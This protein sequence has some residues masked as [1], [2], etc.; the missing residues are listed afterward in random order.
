MLALSVNA[1]EVAP[2]TPVV[3]WGAQ[4]EIIITNDLTEKYGDGNWCL[5][6]DAQQWIEYSYDGT[7]DGGT[8]QTSNRNN[9]WFDFNSEAE[10]CDD[11]IVTSEELN[12]GGYLSVINKAG[13]KDGLMVVGKNR[14]PTFYVTGTDKAKFYFSGASGTKGYPQIEVYEVGSATPVATYTGDYGLTK[15]TWD[16][17]TLLI[18][19]GLN[20]AKSYKIV[21][22]TMALVDD[23]Y[24]YEGGDVVLQVV[25][26]YG[27]QA[28]MRDDGL[29]I[30]GSEIGSYI[31]QHLAVYP[32]ITDF[33]L[34]A[35][36]K[37]TIKEGI[38]A[39]GKFTLTGVASNP[40][41]I[42]A[43]ALAEPFVQFATIAEDAEKDENGFVAATNVRFA[44]IKVNA[45]GQSLFSSGKQNYLI[46]E[47]T[48]DNS[49]V[50]LTG[51]PFVFDFRSGG[52][53]AK[54]AVSNSTVWAANTTSN[55][56]FTSQSGK[57]AT[58]AGLEEQ[59]LSI[60]NSTLSNIAAGRNFCTHRQNGQAWMTYEVKN[61]IIVNCGKDN[62]LASLNGGASSANPKYI[63]EGITVLKTIQDETET[64][65]LTSINDQQSTSDET[66]EIVSPI[67]GVPFTLANA[68]AGN[69][70]LI[71]SS[72]QAKYMT[73]D[74]RWLTPYTTDAIKIEVDQY[75]N[76]D[77]AAVLNE[78]LKISEQPSSITI[79]FYEAGEYPLTQP[80]NTTSPITILHGY[81]IDAGEA[82]IVVHNGMTLGGAIKIDGVN[83]KAGDDLTEPI[84][85]LQGNPYMM[86]DNGYYNLSKIQLQNL[87][88]TDLK[89][90]LIQG[91][92][93][94][95][96]PE[97]ETRNCEIYMADKISGSGN[98][99]AIYDFRMGGVPVTW[100][101]VNSTLD[102]NNNC[103]ISTA[104]GEKAGNVAGVTMQ[105][106]SITNSTI[107]RTAARA[108][109]HRQNSQSWLRYILK[110]SLI[111][112]PAKDN[113]VADMNGG[114]QNSRPVW[115]ISGNAFQRIEDGVATD[116][117]ASQDN[118]DSDEPVMNS[119]LGTMAFNSL[120]TP[121]FGG[122]FTLSESCKT[123]TGLGDPRWSIAY[124]GGEVNTLMEEALAL[125]ADDEAVAVGKLRDAIQWAKDNSDESK[126]QAA[127]DQFKADN[128]D[129]LKDETE[130]VGTDTNS[131]SVGSGN[132]SHKATY[133]HNGIIL[134]EH[135]GETRVGT[136]LSQEVSV[137]N[138]TYNIEVYA[139]SHNA[140]NGS[141]MPVS[142][143]NPAPALQTDANDVAYVFGTSGANTV[144]T[145]IT[146][147]RN[148][149]ML[150]FEPEAYAINDVEV[151][152]GKL[153]IGLALAKAG[154]TEWHTIQIKS[155]KWV[156]TA[157]TAYA[158]SQAEL[159]A[160]VAEAKTLA[161]DA[162]KT[163]GREEFIAVL[164]TA[165][166]A[167]GSN[168]YNIPEVEALIVNLK[169]AI[170]KYR[171]A[172]YFIDF[173][174]GEYY[175]IDTESGLMMAAGHDWGTR[176]IVNELGLDL[177]L[178]PNE[179]TRS[180]S[181]NSRV[182]N[183]GYQN[184]LGFNLYMDADEYGWFLDYQGSS[185]YITNGEGQYISID[186]N[187]NLVMSSTPREWNIVTKDGMMEQRL[188]ELKAA[189]QSD[190]RDATFLL[191][192]PN[193]N[194]NDQ[195]TAAWTVSE[196]CTN[197]TLGGPVYG[198][199]ENYCAESYHSTFTISQNITGAPAGLY[200]L[201]AQG[202][203]RQ[204]DGA[205]ENAPVFFIGSATGE[206]PVIS[207]SENSMADA[208]ASFAAGLYTID[209]IEFYYDGESSLT[210]GIE[211]TATHQWVAFDNFRL[212]YLGNDIDDGTVKLPK[213]LEIVSYG[214]IYKDDSGND[215]FAP[216]NV[217]VDGNDVYFQG[218]SYF[219]PEAWVKGTKDGN[220]VT[221]PA[222]QYVGMH[223]VFGS[224]FCFYNGDA[225]FTYDA[226]TDTYTAEGEFYG[227]MGDIYYDRYV[228]NPVIKRVV[229]MAAMPA[230]PEIAN[231]KNLGYY[232]WYL[233]FNV[234]LVD[235]NGTPLLTSKLAYK[236]YSDT[237]GVIE[238]L[239]FTP[240]THTHLTENMTEIPYGFTDDWD[241]YPTQL[242]LN[243]LYSEEWDKIGIQSIYY[244]GGEVNTTE[245][246]W[247]DLRLV[248]APEDLV[249]QTYGFSAYDTYYSRDVTGEVQ[250]G[251]YG[252]DEVYIQGLSKYLP[253]A[254]V[255]GM[256]VDGTL[257][258]PQTYLGIYSDDDEWT[259]D[260]DVF[261]TGATFSYNEEAGTF[262]SDGGYVSYESPEA[263]YYM[264]EFKYVLLTK[265]LDVAAIPANPEITNFN[266]L[267][268]DYPILQFEI[269]TV[270]INGNSL[271]L[272][273][274]AY[275]IYY[276]KNNDVTTLVLTKDLYPEL[277]ADK[278]ELPYGFKAGDIYPTVIY[279]NQPVE[280][281]D[282]WQMIGIQSIYYGGYE[283][284][285]SD[286]VWFI[287]DNVDGI[288]SVDNAKMDN[289]P[290]YNLAGQRLN[291]PQRG[292]NIINGKKL[293][294]K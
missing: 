178:T 218:M 244:G 228:L 83:L 95:Q 277:D 271:I 90:Q 17:S 272:S 287:N 181:I 260:C 120:E 61:S 239:T 243:G 127:I 267:D 170:D 26:F 274:L 234:P 102:A 47:L 28:P 220:T 217:A 250:V 84:I 129:Q 53:V 257:T 189:A 242:Y 198:N 115:Q 134:I 59:V 125:A 159:A 248:R 13:S 91:I 37:Y 185:F 41:T 160:L 174:V 150:D 154:Q 94:L 43:S 164:E 74:P 110:N 238:A 259:D 268:T 48:V 40:A 209:P 101:F 240:E 176:G 263:E 247:Y 168:W 2:R 212:T 162:S 19:D 202:F 111:I 173:A 294:I 133:D 34:D 199:V 188:E 97:I 165:E 147:R 290:V 7:T 35:G 270:D 52:V 219:F 177:I 100:N 119:V 236:I 163:N 25:K 215:G 180:V 15:S 123:P 112:D 187:N 233:N 142:D 280:Q 85:T 81:D 208:G 201:T 55:Q 5:T 139:T 153:T 192:N 75:E 9:V 152:D 11:M 73:G 80:I 273:K 105:T 158:A 279:L 32:G 78:G 98:T 156:T 231:M 265:L 205:E 54:L 289:V 195:R 42:D 230:N 193:F 211:G 20:K 155:L 86:Q 128:A 57:K 197:K 106:F 63:V 118:G 62:F 206:V 87:K 76:T 229:D 82:T 196:D 24:T 149:G 286:I 124:A 210:V 103:I 283:R 36:G 137:E 223:D 116:L 66:E 107:Y 6:A 264:D 44:N 284:N 99:P 184:Y 71:A 251:F 172:N 214:M 145:W 261:F 166:P 226:E 69:F 64:D 224:S 148:S 292:L 245:I 23:S 8:V 146:A 222:M 227:I 144:Q 256:L 171:K 167:V 235:I 31:N 203:Y 278:T 293:M 77:F 175:I 252:E 140:W 108:F 117:A 92:S 33:T 121:D 241:F 262:Y 237:K 51:N 65:V 16:H 113:F 138:G 50:E 1:Q 130:K 183:G 56:F 114:Q 254:W 276:F 275:Q 182:S 266:Y 190:P 21:A 68:L 291:K 221:F 122:T 204:E 4:A 88:V 151:T 96:I 191:Q 186:M 60:T 246:Q 232:G 18:A 132:N 194:R 255:K 93:G 161:A 109:Q 89:T 135:F 79:Q 3:S 200:Q 282:S 104:G 22:R 29:I 249:T 12:W 157:K 288:R 253:K 225:V 258:I 27:D 216:V 126:L 14:Y 58:E 285:V 131:W 141:Y 39:S 281:I 143:D 67:D 30:D 49:V 70:K 136:M 72:Q 169:T 38:V 213:G 10:G 207:G 46:P 269:P 179:V 45:L